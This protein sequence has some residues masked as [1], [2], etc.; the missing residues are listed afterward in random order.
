MIMG[1]GRLYTAMVTPFK[2]SGA[3][4]YDQAGELALYLLE[5]GSDGLIV[6][7]TTGESP[8]LRTEEKVMLFKAIKEKVGDR[9]HIIAG[10]GCNDTWKTME[11]TKMAE[12]AGVDACMLVVP[13]YNRPPQK[14]LYNHFKRV[15]ECTKL[16]IML[17][18]VP[19]R[20]GQNMEPETVAKLAKIKNIVAVKEASGSLDQI[21]AIR[22]MTN[23]RF[24][25]FSGDDALTLP[26]LSVGGRGV[27][28]VASHLVGNEMKSM[29]EAYLKGDTEKALRINERIYPIFKG[30]FITSNPIPVKTALNLLGHEV[31]GMRMPLELAQGAILKQIEK[32]LLNYGLMTRA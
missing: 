25:I 6:S 23:D 22:R 10:T 9:G 5:N 18:N 30:L 8:C 29:I 15:S 3:V 11:L 14:Q 16:P 20:T 4:D 2:S 32:M 13:Y 19:G 31:G 1:F 12:E 24:M 17:Y 21:I 7:G 27:V 28:S 26:I